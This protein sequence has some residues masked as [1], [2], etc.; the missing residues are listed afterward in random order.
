MNVLQRIA[1]I[2]GYEWR[3]AI[4][5]KW[6]LALIVLALTFEALYIILQS[7]FPATFLAEDVIWVFGVLS[8]QSLFIQLVAILIAGS[9]MSEEYERG[10]ADILLSK[11]IKRIE[12]MAGKFLGGFSL[13][14]LVEASIAVT[15]VVLSFGFFGPQRDLHVFPLLFIAIVYASF[16]FFSLTF[17]FSELFRR[18]T[19]AML[20]ALGIFMVSSIVGSLLSYLY[21]VTNEVFYLDVSR[22]LPTWS[23]ISLPTFLASEYI[24]IPEGQFQFLPS[25]DVQLAAVIVALYTIFFILMASFRLVRSDVT[26]KAE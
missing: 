25:G 9:S 24:T 21:A 13:L 26:K 4:A 7:R 23:A 16:L 3:R 22:L 14:V 10:T 11:P 12:Y 2:A 1:V 18:S 19:M 8:A 5:K 20:V 6:I 17:M 15:G